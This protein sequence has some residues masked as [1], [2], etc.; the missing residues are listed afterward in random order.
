[1]LVVIKLIE[2]KKR[3][4]D[5]L[6]YLASLG[7]KNLYNR[8]N[9]SM[10]CRTLEMTGLSAKIM[11]IISSKYATTSKIQVREPRDRL[12]EEQERSEAGLYSAPTLFCLYTEELA[13]RIRMNA[14]E[15]KLCVLYADDMILSGSV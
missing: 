14:G 3:A 5:N 10:F 11:N 4:G 15:D 7:I 8:V 12:S 2:R 9:M 13:V 6:Y 1:M